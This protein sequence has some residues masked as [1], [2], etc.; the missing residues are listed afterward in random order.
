[1]PIERE[2]PSISLQPRFSEK[3]RVGHNLIFILLYGLAVGVGPCLGSCGLFL[4][5]L[6]GGTRSSPFAGI[7]GVL[8]FSG[9]RVL[10]YLLLGTLAGKLGEILNFLK[11][12]VSHY[13]L[14]GCGIL[15]SLAGIFYF[16]PQSE[17]FCIWRGKWHD[18][19]LPFFLLGIL[20]GIMPCLP[21]S[22]ILAYIALISHNPWEGFLY[23]LSFS[24]GTFI[25][26]L[27][28]IG[29]IAGF[30]S[31]LSQKRR[32]FFLLRLLCGAMLLFMGV[33]LILNGL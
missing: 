8:S 19:K 18:I 29:G 28:V 7:K 1:M 4:F 26:P 3:S 16:I 22:S 24:T 15:L 20:W 14:L 25:S 31:S 33:S 17:K 6:I 23:S 9:G 30:L 12:G 21:L 5:A 32:F 11:G 2:L 27:L 13:L 10:V